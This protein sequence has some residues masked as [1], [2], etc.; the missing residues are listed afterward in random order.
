MWE[1]NL[2]P[3]FTG[4]DKKYK[5]EEEIWSTVEFLESKGFIELLPV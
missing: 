3:D 2:D 4:E 1:M 5:Y